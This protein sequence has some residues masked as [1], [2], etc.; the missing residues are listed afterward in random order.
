MFIRYLDPL[1]EERFF[2][3]I[4]LN[5]PKT[6]FTFDQLTGLIRKRLQKD[7]SQCAKWGFKKL[8]T[9]NAGLVP[10]QILKQALQGIM[11]SYYDPAYKIVTQRMLRKI[12]DRE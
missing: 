4:R 10:T 5:D 1:D 8:D 12:H 6:T 3:K 11:W 9:I 2:D 7:I